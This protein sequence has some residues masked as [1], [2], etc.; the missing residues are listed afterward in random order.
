MAHMLYLVLWIFL[1]TD[2]PIPC[3][4]HPYKWLWTAGSRFWEPLL[5]PLGEH[6][7]LSLRAL[8]PAPMICFW[9]LPTSHTKQVS[10]KHHD[11][12]SRMSVAVVFL[13]GSLGLL[14]LMEKDTQELRYLREGLISFSLGIY[15]AE[16]LWGQK[17]C[18]G[19]DL[20]FHLHVGSRYRTEV[21]GFMH[22]GSHLL[23]HFTGP[24]LAFTLEIQYK[25]N[26]VV[27]AV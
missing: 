13:H 7:C 17:Q 23:S 21:F 26:W 14:W 3:P 16:G 11:T 6:R 10:M 20:S 1:P 5:G 12:L 15:L 2:L 8:S 27:C 18:C 4:S 22:Q 24:V 9:S 25:G 19:I